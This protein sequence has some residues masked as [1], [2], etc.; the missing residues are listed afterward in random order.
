MLNSY[1][2]QRGGYAKLQ[3]Q[4]G[5]GVY[6]QHNV[7]NGLSAP[8][9][10]NTGNGAQGADK[11]DVPQFQTLMLPLLKVMGGGHE[12]KTI[13]MRDAV[14]DDLALT[15]EALSQRLPGGTP[16]TFSNRI[17]WAIT[18]LFKAGLLERPHQATYV[19]SETGKQLLLNPP[20]EIDAEFLR[21][22][23]EFNWFYDS[24]RG[25]YKELLPDEGVCNEPT[26]D[27]QI[28]I[29]FSQIQRELSSEV[30]EKIKLLS[31]ED[32]KK[33]VIN[34]LEIRIGSRQNI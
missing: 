20:L 14:A 29:D 34:L 26:P 17:G 2:T 9:P 31:T 24:P 8:P 6:P 22:Y 30:V 15:A 21:L 27:E 25:E 18:F 28:E 16:N 33:L 1:P 5:Y 3:T 7:A 4:L 19:I 32:F 12:M 11:N 13:Q 23:E 10:V